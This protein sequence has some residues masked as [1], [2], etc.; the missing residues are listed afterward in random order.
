MNMRRNPIILILILFLFNI[1]LNGCIEENEMSIDYII[2]EPLTIQ[3]GESVNLSWKVTGATTVLIDNNIGNVKHENSM[4]VNPTENVT[5]TITAINS[6]KM[7]NSSI[8][9]IVEEKK[10]EK[11]T[12]IVTL[13]A[14]TYNKN[15]SVI[16][17][18]REISKF[19][20]EWSTISGKIINENNGE[21]IPFITMDWR[22]NGIIT[23]RDEI[24]ITNSMIKLEFEPG[25]KYSF[26]L[27]YQLTNEIMGNISWIQ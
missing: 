20:V 5:Y 2:A 23:E 26:L 12:S 4:N 14:N 7:I 25:I 3:K 18:I 17:K 27:T 24:I 10:Q 16:I 1:F 15:S 22:P 6:N 21:I 9:I 8:S 19:G 13:S 11:D